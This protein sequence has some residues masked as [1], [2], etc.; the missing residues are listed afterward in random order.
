M[1][2]SVGIRFHLG[3]SVAE[4]SRMNELK[5]YTIRMCGD[6]P[7]S[8]GST[9]STCSTFQHVQHQTWGNSMQLFDSMQ[10]SDFVDSSYNLGPNVWP[11]L[12][13]Q[14]SRLLENSICNR[15]W[16]SWT[17]APVAEYRCFNRN[18]TSN[19]KMPKKRMQNTGHWGRT[20]FDKE[21]IKTNLE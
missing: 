17:A 6:V 8:S 16:D 5:E 11:W 21:M 10:F 7:N 20:R 18:E 1:A 2:Q 4:C 14:P 13:F 9:C 15:S 3:K 12:K 19:I